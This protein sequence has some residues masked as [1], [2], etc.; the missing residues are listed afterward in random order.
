M[1]SSFPECSEEGS[2][3]GTGSVQYVLA[4]RGLPWLPHGSPL[5][6]PSGG[7]MLLILYIYTYSWFSLVTDSISENSPIH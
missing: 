7:K 5:D 1:G 3:Q 6:L 2:A 4:G